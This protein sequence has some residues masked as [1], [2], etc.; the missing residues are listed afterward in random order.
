MVDEQP[1]QNM[2]CPVFPRWLTEATNASVFLFL[3]IMSTLLRKL[4][5]KYRIGFSPTNDTS[6]FP[7]PTKLHQR[8]DKEGLWSDTGRDN[9]KGLKVLQTVLGPS[10]V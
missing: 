2:L 9:D 3:T 10:A 7:V 1:E 5:I 4:K 6:Q 8:L